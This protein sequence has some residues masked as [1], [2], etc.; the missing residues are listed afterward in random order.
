M[1]K[2]FQKEDIWKEMMVNNVQPDK[3]LKLDVIFATTFQKVCL[4]DLILF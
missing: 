4:F 1:G 3:D 2:F